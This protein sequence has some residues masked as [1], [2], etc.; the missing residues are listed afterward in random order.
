M[1][2]IAHSDEGRSL[3]AAEQALGWPSLASPSG[4]LGLRGPAQSEWSVWVLIALSFAAASLVATLATSTSFLATPW[5][6][7]FP[8][9]VVTVVVVFRPFA[10]ATAFPLTT[11]FASRSFAVA[12]G[13]AVAAVP[14]S[15]PS[16]ASAF[17][18]FAIAIAIT[19]SLSTCSSLLCASASATSTAFLGATATSSSSCT[20]ATSAVH[21]NNSEKERTGSAGDRTRSN[22]DSWKQGRVAR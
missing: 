16:F 4:Q 11:S 10:L 12:A 15:F 19:L 18:S 8:L 13:L 6:S 2:T 7:F 3:C 20:A 5:S 1:P 22:S 17:T 9:S 14:M 21:Q